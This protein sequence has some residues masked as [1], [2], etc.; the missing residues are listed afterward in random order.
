VVN[1][2]SIDVLKECLI[3]IALWCQILGL[4]IET[5]AE[6]G[7]PPPPATTRHAASGQFQLRLPRSLHAQLSDRAE[8]EGV[9]LN[10]MVVT[11]LAQGMA[12]GERTAARSR[13][14]HVA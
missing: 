7:K 5:F 8:Q 2:W 6:E 3:R 10:T 13:P 4:A 12:R 11:L 14:G 9:S 1:S